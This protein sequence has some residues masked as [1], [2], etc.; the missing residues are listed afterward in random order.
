[1]PVDAVQVMEAA[2]GPHSSAALAGGATN[3]LLRT[4]VE[5]SA[6]L[7]S[8]K[9]WAVRDRS[10]PG[11]RRAK[12]GTVPALLSAKENETSPAPSNFPTIR[13]PTKPT[14]PVIILQRTDR[15]VAK[16]LKKYFRCY[17]RLIT[18]RCTEQKLGSVTFEYETVHCCL[19]TNYSGLC[20]VL[21]RVGYTA[22]APKLYDVRRLGRQIAVAGVRL[23]PG[24]L[25]FLV[26]ADLA[27][28]QVADGLTV[29]SRQGSQ[30]AA[31]SRAELQDVPVQACRLGGDLH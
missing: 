6:V 25:R 13:P 26:R 8:S 4:S 11:L 12:A 24:R 15:S 2:S 14:S 27:A 17:S 20:F 9:L 1:M 29:A 16:Q 10:D 21:V 23:A 3:T 7:S 30:E 28:A 18:K 31:Q 22:C 5:V 19:F